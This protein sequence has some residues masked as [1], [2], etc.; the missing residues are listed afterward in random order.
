MKEKQKITRFCQEQLDKWNLSQ[1]G[2][3]LKWNKRRKSWGLCCYRTKTIQLSE[4]FLCHGE[5]LYDTVLHEI[6]HALAGPR[7][8]HGPIWKRYARQ[9]EANP[10][11]TKSAKRTK[12]FMKNMDYKYQYSCNGCDNT[13]GFSRLTNKWTEERVI[14]TKCG[15][16]V[17]YRQRR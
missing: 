1:E 17:S 5:Q 7:A 11:R 2:W 14:C 6:A 3:T 8:G 12:K 4:R 13:G 16:R 15:S 10:S 9:V